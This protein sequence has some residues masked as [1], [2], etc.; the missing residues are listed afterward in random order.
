M[1]KTPSTVRKNASPAL[2]CHYCRI[3]AKRKTLQELGCYVLYQK[4]RVKTALP[5]WTERTPNK[6]ILKPSKISDLQENLLGQLC[7]F[8][9][10]HPA[11]GEWASGCAGLAACLG[12][13]AATNQEALERFPGDSGHYLAWNSFSSAEGTRFSFWKWMMKGW[14]ELRGLCEELLPVFLCNAVHQNITLFYFDF[15]F[16]FTAYNQVSQGF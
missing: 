3:R 4:H 14:R 12:Y 1:F 11:A 16:P 6:N 9:S 7:W 10:P 13:P 15:F 5:S 2:R 8:C